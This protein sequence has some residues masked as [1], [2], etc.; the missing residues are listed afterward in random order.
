MDP[1][2]SEIPDGPLSLP[3]RDGDYDAVT[4]AG[5]RISISHE[6]RDCTVDSKDCTVEKLLEKAWEN[7]KSRRSVW[8]AR[9][10]TVDQDESF[11]LLYRYKAE[12]ERRSPGSI[13][14]I[15]YK[16]VE[17]KQYFTR[18]FCCFKACITG[19]LNGCRPYLSIGSTALDGKWNGHFATVSALDGHDWMFPV[20][21]GFFESESEDNWTWFMRQLNKS[22]G[23]P[24]NL[25]ICIDACE[26]L[27]R[28]V[29]TV[30]PE[31][32][33]RENSAHLMQNVREKWH[34]DVIGDMYS[35]ARAHCPQQ[36][37]QYMRSITTACPD[38]VPWLQQH[39]S[40]M[41]MRSSFNKEVKCDY[42]TNNLAETWSDWVEEVKDLPPADLTDAIRVKIMTL[43]YE[44]RMIGESLRGCILPAVIA[45]LNARTR[46]L[47]NVK[48][49]HGAD[50]IAKV[51]EPE[52]PQNLVR[53]VDLRKKECT[54]LQWQMC[55]K[56]CNHALAFIASSRYE[57]MEK[58][59][60]EYFSVQRFELAYEGLI[61]PLPDKS[62]WPKVD[63]GFKLLPPFVERS[64]GRQK[65]NIILSCLDKG[66][67]KKKKQKYER[68]GEIG[69]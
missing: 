65:K 67:S 57:K 54:C 16:V 34:G 14:E 3:I 28:A 31:A 7:A 47:G 45:Q 4:D 5:S 40:L 17:G 22:I 66:S 30:F 44:R 52:N 55:G 51:S 10:G 6:D 56:P 49:V 32:E 43:F 37:E 39:H 19:F 33:H 1:P 62:Q 63:T 50:G 29:K 36:F 25:A 23:S 35:A 46:G 27:Q 38:V 2:Y 42:I 18:F 58:H 64:I 68:L 9:Q 59:V 12:V 21:H 15:D 11:H 60:H 53:H 24:R 8:A 48:V 26:G 13:L 20:A 61:E 69:H 41:W